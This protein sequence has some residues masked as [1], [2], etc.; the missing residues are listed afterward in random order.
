MTAEIVIMNSLGIAMAAD[1]AVTIGGGPT[2][3]YTSADKLFQLTQN[4]PVGIMIYGAARLLDVPWETVIKMY[5]ERL[6]GKSFRSLE[7]YAE[8]LVHF[9]GNNRRLFPDRSQGKFIRVAALSFYSYFFHGFSLIVDQRLKKGQVN[10]TELKQLLRD[11]VSKAYEATQKFPLLKGIRRECPLILSARY[12]NAI[13]DSLREVFAKLP[14]TRATESK[15]IMLFCDELCRTKTR[16]TFES[17][18][19]IAGFGRNDHFPHVKVYSIRGIAGNQLI[20]HHDTVSSVDDNV[21]ARI[22]PFAQSEMVGTF[23]DGI[24]P[25][26]RQFMENTTKELLHGVADGIIAH[27]EKDN[28]GMAEKLRLRIKPGLDALMQELMKM[29]DAKGRKEYS[30]PIMEMVGAQPKDELA[31]MA[32]ALVEL[33]KF[34]RR[35]SRQEETVGGPID[36]AVIT[37]G[38]G[39]VWIKRKYYFDPELNPRIMAQYNQRAR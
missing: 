10:E 6:G 21:N 7:E 36:V 34:K 24:D 11:Y 38:D 30:G 16:P 19:V 9:I 14:R 1:S 28:A 3:I 5:R 37:K 2:K 17:G 25:L 8:D 39:F 33:T 35:V 20:Y 22:I 29:W 32:E 31:A 13:V 12:K 27:V 4:A 26:L 15:L 18:I 23:M